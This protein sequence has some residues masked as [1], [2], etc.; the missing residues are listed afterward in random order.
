MAI[1]FGFFLNY[2]DN[3]FDQQKSDYAI[4]AIFMVI[5]FLM[6][7]GSFL[8]L[9]IFTPINC[10]T[11]CLYNNMIKIVCRSKNH[12][13]YNELEEPLVDNYDSRLE[14]LNFFMM[15]YSC[16]VTIK[17]AFSVGGLVIQ[18][19]FFKTTVSNLY[20][21]P[22]LLILRFVECSLLGNLKKW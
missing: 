4:W 6:L 17:I 5:F 21:W 3:K 22:Y 20:I 15:K 7:T 14:A 19:L 9:I 10:R 11:I 8:N 2:A 16:L 1:V 13:I 12:Q 18:F